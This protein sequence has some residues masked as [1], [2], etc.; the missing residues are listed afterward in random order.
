MRLHR[1]CYRLSRI[2]LATQILSSIKLTT[3]EFVDSKHNQPSDSPHVLDKKDAAI[4]GAFDIVDTNHNGQLDSAEFANY[5]HLLQNAL[6]PLLGVSDWNSVSVNN[7]TSFR[8]GPRG[9][10]ASVDKFWAGFASGILSIWATEVGDKTFFIAAILSMKHDRIIVF[11]GAIGALIVMTILSVVMGG[12]AARFLPKYMTHYAGAMLFVIF[13]LKMLYDSR[14]M[15]DSGPSSELNEV[16]EELAGRRNSGDKDGAIQKEDQEVMLEH[17]DRNFAERN[18][19]GCESHVNSTSEMIQ[20]FTQ[21]FLLTF[22]AEW[23]DRSQIATIT[24]S[25]TNDPFGGEKEVYVF[26]NTSNLM[27]HIVTLGAILGHSMC[28]GLAVVGGKI[29][30]SRITER[31]V[32]IVGGVLFLL[33]AFHSFVIGPSA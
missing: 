11:A 5:V 16:E 17:G 4:Q 33:F 7:P 21:S 1:T 3:N 32:T 22:L 18:D 28:T 15:S 12:V 14:D 30:A 9:S 10:R 23:G 19:K 2:L 26:S 13:G 6:Q 25:A 29:L 20:M 27:I 31:T 8:T 24:L